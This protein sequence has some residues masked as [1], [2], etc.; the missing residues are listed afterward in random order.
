MKTKEFIWIHKKYFCLTC[1]RT[2]YDTLFVGFGITKLKYYKFLRLPKVIRKY[3]RKF[4]IRYDYIKT[5]LKYAFKFKPIYVIRT[6]Y[7]Y[8]DHVSSSYPTKYK[9]GFEFWTIYHKDELKPR[10]IDCGFY[11]YL[12]FIS[13]DE[14]EN[15]KS[16]TRD[17]GMEAFE[18]G[19]P[20]TIIHD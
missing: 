17:Y 8:V 10:D 9:N 15:S 3:W 5:F 1:V 13:K 11:L 4:K 7:D 12:D 2:D 16:S 20:S 18:N 6:E 14:Y 19:H